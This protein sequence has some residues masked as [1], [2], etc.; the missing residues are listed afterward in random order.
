MTLVILV[1]MSMIDKEPFEHCSTV[2]FWNEDRESHSL[3]Y[4]IHQCMHAT[5]HP[6]IIIIIAN[7]CTVR[8]GVVLTMSYL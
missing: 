8:Q 6:V 1:I 7:Q 4:Y 5:C 2:I 3:P